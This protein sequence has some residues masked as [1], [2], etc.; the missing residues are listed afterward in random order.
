MPKWEAT[1]AARDRPDGHAQELRGLHACRWP[2]APC[3]GGADMLASAIAMGVNPAKKPWP[4]PRDEELLDRG[5]QS[6]RAR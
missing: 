3:R 2:P 4:A 1:Y 6:H 5:H